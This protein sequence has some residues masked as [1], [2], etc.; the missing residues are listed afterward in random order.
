[1]PDS[2]NVKVTVKP[3]FEDSNGNFFVIVIDDLFQKPIIFCDLKPWCLLR[4]PFAMLQVSGHS[5]AATIDS[6]CHHWIPSGHHR[7]L[8]YPLFV[9]D[10]RVF[11]G[12]FQ[13]ASIHSGQRFKWSH[14]QID[15]HWFSIGFFI[16][17]SFSQRVFVV[18]MAFFRPKSCEAW[19]SV[20]SSSAARRLDPLEP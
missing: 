10:A 14:L 9:D 18:A 5:L 11:S 15:K 7:K 13:L 8:D 1:M 19:V 2:E 12:L 6:S 20:H 4:S 3:I 16:I 17:N